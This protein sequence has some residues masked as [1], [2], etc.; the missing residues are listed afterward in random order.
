MN[1]FVDIWD[2][3]QKGQLVGEKDWNMGLFRKLTE[4]TKKYDISRKKEEWINTDDEILERVFEAAVEFISTTGV[5]CR[6]L[7]RVIRFSEDEVRQAVESA[8]SEVTVGAG[9]E[10]RTM[11][12][13]AIEDPRP[14]H[15]LGA[16]HVAFSLEMIPLIVQNVVKLLPRID[17]MEGF[18][19]K[20]IEGREIDN[21]GIAS[22]AHIKSI[23]AH[24]RSLEQAGAP[25]IAIALYPISTNPICMTSPIGLEQGL[26]KS[27]G[28]MLSILP[29]FKVESGFI[30]SAIIYEEYGARLRVNGCD[31][32]CGGT[33]AGSPQ[34][35]LVENAA[36]AMAAWLCYGDVLHN[37]TVK[38]TDMMGCKFHLFGDISWASSAASQT[39]AKKTNFIG[40][41]DGGYAF[42]LG[43]LES[44]KAMALKIIRG[45]VSGANVWVIRNFAP[46][47][48]CGVSPMDILLAVEIADAVVEKGLNR[49]EA[50][51]LV[52]DWVQELDG[53]LVPPKKGTRVTD[54]FDLEAGKPTE[55]YYANYMF[56]KDEL[57]KRGLPF[58]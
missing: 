15:V 51:D 17:Y 5:Y 21:V 19:F 48:D 44:L 41:A 6:D 10:Q 3:A 27:D 42:E 53:Q 37:V 24:R 26:R 34:N 36:Q 58:H 13:M 52:K 31:G 4:L 7:E 8:P 22:Y 38:H 56:I 49:Q 23:E 46:P 29:D 55:A 18:N 32:F 57:S 40:L 14:R 1:R 33:F 50:N 2:R 47:I 12:H 43:T 54:V 28:V 35:A 30:S 25:G 9:A 11:T 45:T 16:G 39:A 20:E